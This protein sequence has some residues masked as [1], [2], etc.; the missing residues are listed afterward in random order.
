MREVRIRVDR[1]KRR[2]GTEP[3]EHRPSESADARAIFDEQPRILPV[4]G[5]E[6]L[7]DQH[8]ARRDDRSDHHRILEEA[9]QELPAGA[10]R[11]PIV[12]PLEAARTLHGSRG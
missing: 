8:P 3:V 5:T 4:D 6:H 10:R 2:I 12:P 1:Q 7:V 9:T 11:T